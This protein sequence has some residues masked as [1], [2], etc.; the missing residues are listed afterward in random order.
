MALVYRSYKGK[1]EDGTPVT[2]QPLNKIVNEGCFDAEAGYMFDEKG[3]YYKYVSLRLHSSAEKEEEAKV[4]KVKI[5]KDEVQKTIP[6]L[7]KNAADIVITVDVKITPL[8]EDDVCRHFNE[9]GANVERKNISIQLSSSHIPGSASKIEVG[10]YYFANLPSFSKFKK[11][12]GTLEIIKKMAEGNYWLICKEKSDDYG[13]SL[14]AVG[15]YNGD[16]GEIAMFEHFE[17]PRAWGNVYK[18]PSD[19]NKFDFLAILIDDLP[20]GLTPLTIAG[21]L[22]A[23]NGG[24]KLSRE[25]GISFSTQ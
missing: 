17:D 3:N 6:D 14:G 2:V 15:V 21:I 4:L 12:P 8:K 24:K 1:L 5:P 7:K 16:N 22:E 10:N 11:L 13:K 25:Q 19:V 20:P 23:F 18:I 9:K